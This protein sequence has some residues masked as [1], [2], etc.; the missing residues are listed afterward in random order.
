M[1]EV[2]IYR[3]TAWSR[4]GWDVVAIFLVFMALFQVG[5]HLA[6]ASGGYASPIPR[7]RARGIGY[8][9]ESDSRHLFCM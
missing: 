1:G 4:G 5:R 8:T 2:R 7:A 9:L 6:R 3:L